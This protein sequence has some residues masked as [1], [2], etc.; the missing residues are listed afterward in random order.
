V[1]CGAEVSV[2]RVRQEHP[3]ARGSVLSL[4]LVIAVHRVTDL[5]QSRCCSVG[6]LSWSLRSRNG[7][8]T[9]Q[10]K[11]RFVNR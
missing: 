7:K 4:T 1:R 3:L 8:C 10:L 11:G 5:S 9:P 2:A 6:G